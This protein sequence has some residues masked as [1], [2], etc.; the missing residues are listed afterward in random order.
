MMKNCKGK[1]YSKKVKRKIDT[2]HLGKIYYN[3]VL[4]KREG[5]F[6]QR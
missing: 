4:K 2:I 5:M 6:P 3:E 1:R